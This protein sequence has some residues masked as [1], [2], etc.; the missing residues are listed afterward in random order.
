MPI[1]PDKL[2]GQLAR[3]LPPVV[4]LGGDEPL[5][6]E[7]AADSVRRTARERGYTERQVL[8]AEPG[9]DWSILGAQAATMSLFGEQRLLEL[10]LPTG[11]PGDAG[12]KALLAYADHLPDDTVLLVICGALDAAARRSKWYKALEAAG[13]AVQAWPLDERRFP[14][15]INARLARAGL[16]PTPEALGLL[17]ERTEGN[18]LA[19]RQEVTK[20]ALLCSGPEV[21][22]QTV[23]AAVGDSARYS[24]FEL[25]D[26]ALSGQVRPAMRMLA[27]LREEGVEPPL[28]LWGLTRELRVMVRA[29]ARA[30]GGVLSDQAWGQLGVQP[31]RKALLAKALRRHRTLDWECLLALAARA[32]RVAKGV[33]PGSVWIEVVNLVSALAGAQTPARAVAIGRI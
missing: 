2:D 21:D 9:F 7:E 26:A 22:A 31:R 11:K 15:W 19:A 32:D 30:D 5:L 24:L 14:G 12:A 27:A 20:L 25:V 10:R 8:F 6:I 17:V 4:V 29:S 18:L 3:G 28:I 23:L 16:R 1:S 13:V 33:T